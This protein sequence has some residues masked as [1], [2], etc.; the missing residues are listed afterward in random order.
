MGTPVRRI[1]P[2]IANYVNRH[3]LELSVK[4]MK[5]VVFSLPKP[6]KQNKIG[7]PSHNPRIVVIFCMLK[8]MFCQTYDSIENMSRDPR[9]K[10]ILGVK[11]LPGHSVVHRGM[12]KL[13]QKYIRRV[14]R[15][16]TKKFKRKGINL[17]VDS[18]GFKTKTSSAWYDIRIKRK[19]RKKD[20]EK[21]HALC[22]PDDG[23]IYD[24]RI[25]DG[26]AHDSP[27]LR[28]M[29]N[30]FNELGNV[31]GDSGYLSRK[32]CQAVSDRGGKPY[33]K[34]KINVKARS[35]SYPAWRKMIQEFK[36]HTTI[37]FNVYHIRSYV[38]ALFSGVKRRFD[39]CLYSV[40]KR[41][42]RRE[43]ALKV[44]CYNIKQSLFIQLSERLGT[45]LW[46][47]P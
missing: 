38:E 40:K 13:R 21:L 33:F 27:H 10:K 44:I 36:E 39:E 11:K 25:T 30:S 24:Y 17:A 26:K 28:P 41:V 23:L 43:L 19:N 2:R 45:D 42:R 32:N 3:L 12:L 16:L 35:E 9:I 47:K 8:V 29:L 37:W 34:P 14:N 1:N 22:S 20:F 5:K 15:K 18:T 7:R 46:I 4:E 31:A 6:W